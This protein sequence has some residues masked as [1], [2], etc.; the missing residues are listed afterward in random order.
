MKNYIII[1]F[2]FLS[3]G[4]FTQWEKQGVAS[5]N[6]NDLKKMQEIGDILIGTDGGI[7]QYVSTSGGFFVDLSQNLPPSPI[8]KMDELYD[9]G[10]LQRYV[11][12]LTDIGVFI[13]SDMTNWI[14]A[15]E[16]GLQNQTGQPIGYKDPTGIALTK[17]LS[18]SYD[19][20]LALK[21]YGI[22]KR[23]FCSTSWCPEQPP[24]F[25]DDAE[26][27]NPWERTGLWH[28]DECRKYSGNTSFKAGANDYPNCIN[29]YP[30]NT[31]SY[32]TLNTW[33]D[34]GP[35]GHGY[36]LRFWEWYYTEANHDYCYV[37]ITTDGNTWI[38]LAGYFGYSDWTQ[39]SISLAEYSGNIRIRFTFTTDASNEY[40]GW[41]ID[42]I[43]ISRD[44][45]WVALDP[46]IPNTDITD[47]YFYN[48]NSRE[49]LFASTSAGIYKFDGSSW[50]LASPSIGFLSLDGPPFTSEGYI[51]A[52]SMGQGVFYTT[53]AGYFNRWNETLSGEIVSVSVDYTNP[54]GGPF[55]A[56]SSNKFYKLIPGSPNQHIE[57]STSFYNKGQTVL[58]DC[59]SAMAPYFYVGTKGIG[60]FSLDC[61]NSL[62][63]K[64]PIGNETSGATNYLPAKNITKIE[65]SKNYNPVI[66][67]SSL[68]DGLYKSTFP[69]GGKDYFVRY[70]YD[71]SSGGT[72]MGT[73][74]AIAPHY[75]E[76]AQISTKKLF[77]FLGTENNGVF[78]STDGGS[79]WEKLNNSPQN[80]KIVDIVVSPDFLND[81]IIFLLTEN[82]V[83]YK[84]EDNGNNW[85]MEANFSSLGVFGY[86]LE[87]SPNFSTDGVLC[88][89][90]TSGLFF[91]DPNKG[92]IRIF[93]SYPV[94]SVSLSPAFDG[95][96]YPTLEGRT[97]LIGTRGQ[98][99]WY[100]FF[101]EVFQKIVGYG[102]DYLDVPVIRFHP[103]SD[104]G[105]TQDSALYTLFL[106]GTTN[107]VLSLYSLEYVVNNESWIA[108]NVTGNLALEERRLSDIAF[109][110]YFNRNIGPFDIYLGHS[111]KKIYKG[112]I[113]GI[114]SWS[115]ESGF[116]HT[117][118]FIYSISEAPDDPNLVLAGTKGYGPMVSFDR[119]L[120]Y[121]PFGSLQYDGYVLH[122]VP[123]ISITHNTGSGRN[124][125]ASSDDNIKNSFG[126][127]YANYNFG[128]PNW[129]RASLCLPPSDCSSPPTNYSPSNFDGHLVKEIR[130]T[131]LLTDIEAADFAA[132]PIMSDPNQGG[133]LGVYWQVDVGGPDTPASLS[134]LTFPMSYSFG[135]G[136]GTRG[137][138]IWGAQGKSISSLRVS[139]DPGAY[140]WS[141][142]TSLWSKNNGNGNYALPEADWRAIYSISEN[143]VLIGASDGFGIYKTEDGGY[144]WRSANNGLES[145]SKKVTA[146]KNNNNYLFVSIEESS[147]GSRNGGVYLS[148]CQAEGYSWVYYSSGMACS[149]TYEL[150]VGSMIYTGS[151][152]DGIYG[153]ST[154]EYTESPKAYFSF[155]RND[156]WNE[157]E[158][159]FYDRSAGLCTSDCST[160]PNVNWS[161]S[162]DDG[163]A[164]TSQNPTHTFTTSGWHWCSI[165]VQ[166]TLYS[167]SD[168]YGNWVYIPEVLSL[169]IEK[170]GSNPRLYWQRFGD[171][172][173]EGYK[174]KVYRSTDPQ[175][176]SLVNLITITPPDPTYC[177]ST[178][179]WYEDTTASGSAYYYRIFTY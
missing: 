28:L 96:N 51:L 105:S 145:T 144:R 45:P 90:T 111:N 179:C 127:Y 137:A 22:Y 162:C 57:Y 110:P 66:F 18:G 124:L 31:T 19:I 61:N 131:N 94:L 6:I 12:V 36:F 172:L 84:S 174:Y 2:L 54:N 107:D 9:T 125:I 126:I 63:E 10:I 25:Y 78:R 32:L 154:V 24:L 147:P 85:E 7:F 59:S 43:E 120:S 3:L 55:S 153:L 168:S 148:D 160:C 33:I 157:R 170:S 53:S 159:N 52:G 99:V 16:K 165:Y 68:S 46:Q 34:L 158:V 86:D 44:A 155:E 151:T 97:I 37:E 93:S 89:A 40:E 108:S 152:C 70:F 60:L 161:W 171:D 156:N 83:V 116:F 95:K 17:N 139:T 134:D 128:F 39:R 135:P 56:I 72:Q 177:D 176:S 98:G 75:D 136:R 47:L 77:V 164:S 123:S 178:Y 140:K 100:S 146:I 67:A 11:S 13:K 103:E 8:S 141:N 65:L 133:S 58:S 106:G 21:G 119:G 130:Y 167:Y 20:Y 82:A 15:D 104:I 23:S 92:W 149:S 5:G 73:C 4:A 1:L 122:N 138:W 14:W 26:D 50:S 38:P 117:P 35:P 42:D 113:Q 143:E 49:Y 114:G 169:K 30:P 142:F 76:N 175:G 79:T 74:L 129:Q 64:K 112:Y 81:N 150:S 41:Y 69:V 102:I 109:H 62:L 101:P 118:P 27:Y 29:P 132:G 121:Y 80:V 115:Q 166:N 88:A 163:F 87:I 48:A 173:S 71:P 91:K